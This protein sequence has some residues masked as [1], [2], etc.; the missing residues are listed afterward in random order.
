M[1][2][3]SW[4]VR[5]LG[6]SCKRKKI[7][8]LVRARGVDL[9]MLQETKRH[10]MSDQIVK[11][12]WPWDQFNFLFVDAEGSAGCLLCIWKPE[13]ITMVDCCCNRSF[14]LFRYLL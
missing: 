12:M 14:I 7:K 4:N 11:S 2:M 5:G 1:K 8:E 9:V 10:V 6:K 3:L 13:V